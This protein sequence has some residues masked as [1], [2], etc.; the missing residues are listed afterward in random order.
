M[1]R[2]CLAA[3]LCLG[4]GASA[5]AD[6]AAHS[7]SIAV[8]GDLDHPKTLTLADLQHEPQTTVTV[9]QHTGHG[10]LAGA[11]TGVLLWTLLQEAGVTLDKGKKNDLIHHTVTVTGSDGY[12]AVL[13]LGEIAPEIG[14]D[15]AVIAWQQDGKPLDSERGFAR[16]IIPGD[17]AASRAVSAI[18]T[19]EVK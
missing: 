12:N 7:G 13:S 10:T 19:I 9:S 16:M 18:T 14:D 1:V 6:P 5:L 4:L 11:F 15:K 17:K 8:K 2:T 3:F